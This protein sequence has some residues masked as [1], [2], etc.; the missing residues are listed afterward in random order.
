[1][2]FDIVHAIWSGWSG[3]TATGISTLLR[4]PS[5][6]HIA[7]GELASIPQIAYGGSR[8]WHGRAR[9]AFTL[10]A[11]SVITAASAPVIE[12]LAEL[13]FEAQRVP[14][15]VDL[16]AWPARRPVKRDPLRRA[17]LIHVASL[18]RV[19]D[20]TTLLR[21]LALLAG[22]GVD[23]EL[24]LIGEDTLHGE[25]QQLG[26]RLGL[27]ERVRF[28]G[29]LTQRQMRPI[30]L[31]GDLMVMSSLHE[32]GP[33]VMLEA[34]VLG[35]P[36]VGTAVGH[37]REWSPHAAVSVPVG[38][39]GRLAQAI[40][41]LLANEELRMRLAHSAHQRALQE[42]ADYTAGCFQR[43]YARLCPTAR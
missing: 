40:A 3:L 25:I 2:P 42:D 33:L 21:A 8:S 10:R 35:I 29:F 38:D 20:Q 36:T 26:A 34:A 24:D 18:N 37:V 17:R 9:E 19:K 1:M 7:G 15:G 11:A 43:L 13:G 14:L 6:V 32:T 23:F 31:A 22:S 41:G 27:A 30:M 16:S 12:R 28:H 4:I 39:A 5:L